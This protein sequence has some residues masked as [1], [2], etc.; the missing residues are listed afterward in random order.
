MLPHS[1]PYRGSSKI[2]ALVGWIRQWSSAWVGRPRRAQR[3]GSMSNPEHRAWKPFSPMGAN[4]S[5][6]DQHFSPVP[7][8][9]RGWFRLFIRQSSAGSIQQHLVH[10]RPDSLP[11]TRRFNRK[12]SS[13]SGVVSRPSLSLRI[14]LESPSRHCRFG[15]KTI[16]V[17]EGMVQRQEPLTASNRMSNMYRHVRHYIRLRSRRTR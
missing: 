12:H 16:S 13:R 9:D 14:K 6:G 10:V 11:A 8:H 3:C 17:L 2:G 5:R 4:G 1:T 15:R 7:R